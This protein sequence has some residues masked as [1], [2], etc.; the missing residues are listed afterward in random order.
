MRLVSFSHF[1]LASAFA[2]AAVGCGGELA[3]DGSEDDAQVTVDA[4]MDGDVVLMDSAANADGG[5]GDVGVDAPLDA[6][7]CPA[8]APTGTLSTAFQIDSAHTGAQPGDVVASP[9]CRRWQR[10]FITYAGG[11]T[12]APLILPGRVVAIDR[13]DVYALN[14]DDGAT[15][16]GPSPMD[17][18]ELASDGSWVF[19]ESGSGYVAALDAATA[20]VEWQ[21][22]RFPDQSLGLMTVDNGS[23]VISLLDGA[24]ALDAHDG[25]LLWQQS[26]L[27]FTC[28]AGAMRASVAYVVCPNQVVLA[29]D[30]VT[31]QVQWQ[32]PYVQNGPAVSLKQPVVATASRLLLPDFGGSHLLTIDMSNGNVTQTAVPAYLGPAVSATAVFV[33]TFA[34][35]EAW[36]SDLSQLLWSFQGD[37]S[38]YGAPILVGSQ[39]VIGSAAHLYLLDAATGAL[40]SQ[41]TLTAP[42]TALAEADGALLVATSDGLFAY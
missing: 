20:H 23:L 1:A 35:L 13:G 12:F 21:V 18:R 25:H 16:W 5:G 42:P 29:I 6:S 10:D 31:G 4:K 33:L 39:V 8:R 34:G 38:L 41:D 15:L 37:G 17:A 24:Y 19:V 28:A 11:N 26:T 36:S 30:A 22:P 32:H 14:P 40:V 9:L 2:L 27:P 3:C 7:S